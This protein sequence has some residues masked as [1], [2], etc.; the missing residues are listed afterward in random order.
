[1]KFTMICRGVDSRES[2]ETGAAPHIAKLGKLLKSYAPDLVQL[3]GAISKSTRKEEYSFALNLNLPTGTMHCV[4]IGSDVRSTL[5]EAFAELESQL[6]KHKEHVRHDYE[7][8]RKRPRQ[9]LLSRHAN[10]N[11]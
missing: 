10:T 4:G 7:W 9:Q 5:K 11:A 3:H 6:K 8:K 1:M 2:V